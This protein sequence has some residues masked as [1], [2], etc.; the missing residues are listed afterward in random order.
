VF[1]TLVAFSLRLAKQPFLFLH[2][3]VLILWFLK[4]DSGSWRPQFP[5]QL[6]VLSATAAWQA[7]NQAFQFTLGIFFLTQKKKKKTSPFSFSQFS[8]H[9][10]I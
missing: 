8:L 10:V 2:T 9:P 6:E 5:Q 1:Y 3:F 4:L 7:D